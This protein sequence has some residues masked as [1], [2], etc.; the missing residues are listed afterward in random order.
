MSPISASIVKHHQLPTILHYLSR[1][2][3]R[4]FGWT[5]ILGQPKILQMEAQ[6]VSLDS[7][8][9][10]D[11][12]RAEIRVRQYSIRTEEVYVYWARRYILYHNNK[13]PKNMGAEQRRQG[14]GES[15]G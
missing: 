4:L 12:L 6:A 11:R 9:F 2:F 5:L 3:G 1:L 8:K 10:L 14:C 13:H 7:P 15:V